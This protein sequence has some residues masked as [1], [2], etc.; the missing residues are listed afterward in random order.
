M[1]YSPMVSARE[2]W[3]L[4]WS[5]VSMGMRVVLG[6]GVLSHATNAKAEARNATAEARITLLICILHAKNRI[7]LIGGA[8]YPKQR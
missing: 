5:R 8:L 7:L 2:G 1:V 4:E 6:L 3:S